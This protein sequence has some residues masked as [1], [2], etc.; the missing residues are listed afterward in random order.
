MKKQF[1]ILI[2]EHP[3]LGRLAYLYLLEDEG[4]EYFE[5]IDRI[6]H[7]N[8]HQY[9]S[10]LSPK[11]LKI[12][13][14]TEEYSNVSLKK[15]FS[16]KNIS[17]R[18]FVNQLENEYVKKFIR[19]VISRCIAR[20][21]SLAL[22]EQL[23][24][25]FRLD[26]QVAIYQGNE[27]RIEPEPASIVFNFEKLDNETRYYQTIRHNGN[28]ISLTNKNG[29][30]LTNDPCWLILNKKLYHFKEP[31]DG[32]KLQIFFSKEFMQVPARL[33]VNYFST[34]IKS[35][36][37]KFPVSAEGF[38]VKEIIPEKKAELSLENALSGLPALLLRFLYNDDLILPHSPENKYVLFD[39]G[40][41]FD[42]RF[43]YR[44]R[45][46][47]SGIVEVITKLGLKCKYE[48]CYVLSG[49]ENEQYNLISWLNNNAEDLEKAGIEINQ[50]YVDVSYYTGAVKMEISFSEQN[51]WFDV[52]AV[53]KFGD[54]FEVPMIQLRK[55]LLN[56]IR[57]YELPDGQVAILPGHWF[58][59]YEDLVTF[60][61]KAP[62]AIKVKK[63]HFA[64]VEQSIA[65][66]IEVIKKSK[67]QI[68]NKK[69]KAQLA[70]PNGI[71]AKLRTYQLE[72]FRWL[73]KMRRMELGA[74]LAD[75]MGLG[76]TL[77]TLCLLVQNFSENEHRNQKGQT[78][79]AASGQLDLF[80]HTSP[81]SIGMPS[82]VIMPASLLHNWED[83]IKKFAPSIKY[84][85]YTGQQRHEKLKRFDSVDLL[86]TTYGTIRNDIDA[87]AGIQFD[88]IILD[89]SQL[90]KNPV[91]KIARAV[92]HLRCK[93][94]IALTGTPIENSLIDLW[95]QMNFL[96]RGLLGDL[97]F[98]KRYFATPIEKYNDPVKQEKLQTLIRPFL[99][100]R[101]KLQVEKELPELN[102]EFIRCEM[103]QEQM[104]L[105]LEEKSR[106]RNHI[107]KSIEE[108]GLNRSG[109]TILQGLSKLRQMANHPG[110]VFP[111]YRFGSGKY[112]EKRNIKNR[113]LPEHGFDLYVHA[114]GQAKI[115][116]GLLNFYIKAVIS[117]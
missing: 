53:A 31:V 83:E 12:V 89:E 44:D 113:L 70:V 35:C 82:M 105:Y 2:Q 59:K 49:D 99:L 30:I 8:L 56:G 52:Y 104:Q 63:H 15:R 80:A 6:N 10:E 86:L 4:K 32:K 84:L 85:N 16:N 39:A 117:G 115:C 98:F 41:G 87:L 58:E 25:F 109:I 114:C 66:K 17:A 1:A 91:S 27:I 102:E 62:K 61:E 79:Q 9:K 42:F 7:A 14:E 20:I 101:T 24:V 103:S 88:Y 55:H 38:K 45:N 23:H 13:E 29:A 72:G 96:N 3:K 94:R 26:Q 76:K 50:K 47:E 77:Q 54:D 43:F 51:D 28:N 78:M 18:D 65:D 64:L 37:Q 100:R 46:W 106:I 57:E 93:R 67:K 22:K 107:L 74:C 19:P 34:F 97:K 33:E 5:I 40:Q 75:D 81:E 92:Q 73:N 71:D 112:D 21:V 68:V 111:D 116:S 11:L 95:S 110:M 108:R 90:I 36:I 69:E 48:N 60:G